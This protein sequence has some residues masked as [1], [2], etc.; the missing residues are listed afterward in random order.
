MTKDE[1]IEARD[2]LMLEKTL[3]FHVLASGS[4]LKKRGSNPRAS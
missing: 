3:K 1:Y 4:N 2:C